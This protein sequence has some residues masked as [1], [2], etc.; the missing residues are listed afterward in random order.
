MRTHFCHHSRHD[1]CQDLENCGFQDVLAATS[2]LGSLRGDFPTHTCTAVLALFLWV[3]LTVSAIHCLRHDMSSVS[4]CRGC[5]QLKC[6]GPIVSSSCTPP[7]VSR[8]THLSACCVPSGSFQVW[9]SV[10]NSLSMTRRSPIT[11]AV[12]RAVAAARQGSANIVTQDFLGPAR[13]H[14]ASLSPRTNAQFCTQQHSRLTHTLDF[15]FIH[16][17]LWK[18]ATAASSGTAAERQAI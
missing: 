16:T 9:R 11:T 4:V 2:V 10:L 18:A 15:Q 8:K 1:V 3:R 12:D 5:V 7:E 13:S 6:F 14:V 17:I